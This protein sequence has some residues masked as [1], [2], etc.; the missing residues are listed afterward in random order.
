MA[1][2]AYYYGDHVPNFAQYKATDPAGVR[3]GYD[4][5]VLT[6]EALLQR[7]SVRQGRLV[8]PEGMSYR[9]L[10]LPQREAISLPVLRRLRE[11]VAAGAVVLGPKPTR[12]TSLRDYPACDAEVQTLARE[13]WEAPAGR[14]RVIADR[15][16]LEVLH[17][18]GLKPDFQCR[19]LAPPEAAQRLDWIH[20]R[21]DATDIYFLANR[22]NLADRFLCT[23]RVTDRAPELWNPVN[24]ERRFATSY[25]RSEDGITLPLDFA[26]CG[27][28]FVVFRRPVEAHPPSGQ[29]NASSLEPLRDL[30]GPWEVRFDPAW[31]GPA[32]ATFP[33]LISWTER[34]EPGIR[35]YSGT[36]T[37]LKRFE[38]HA[39]E[40]QAAAGRSV[41]LDLGRVRELAEVRLNGQPLGVLWTPPFCVELTGALRQGENQLEIDV[42]NFWPNRII[43]DASLPPP[44][45]RTRT[46]IR[47]LTAGTPLMASGLMGPVRL[48][49]EEAR[50]AQPIA[51]TPSRHD[52]EPGA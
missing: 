34:P 33:R 11:L 14:P 7:V 31:G 28:W 27:S 39:T 4:Y 45:R 47:K 8:L 19:P 1:D 46:N 32:S 51:P 52:V 43:G 13:L 3:P 5:D 18:L 9:L 2:V 35:F 49:V 26:P 40:V 44:E 6:E 42:V 41:W 38:W 48:M 21:L 20:R 29:P 37:Y 15:S 22:T 16:P 25:Q 24:G 30:T 23:F 12:A 36:A 50:T 10:V 17:E